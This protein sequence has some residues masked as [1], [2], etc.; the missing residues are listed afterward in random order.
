MDLDQPILA[1]ATAKHAGPLGKSF[2]LVR[3]SSPNVRVMALKKA[4]ES[5]DLVVRVVEIAGKPAAG[6]RLAFVSAVV[7]VREI[8]AQERK[9]A[10]MQIDEGGIAI[11]LSP[12]QLR[13]FAL[14]LSPPDFHVPRVRSQAVPLKTAE[15]LRTLATEML[16]SSLSYGA[17]TFQTNGKA[18]VPRGETIELPTGFT[19]AYILAAAISGDQKARFNDR[20][21]TIEDW[22]G[23]I[24]QWDTR[25]WQTRT[26]DLPPR[27]D[28]PPNAPPRTRTSTEFAG[29][30]P[31]FIKPAS[32]AWYAS[33]SHAAD[34]SNL[35]YQYSYLFAYTLPLAGTTLTLPDNDKIRIVAITVS[36]EGAP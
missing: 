1:F 19:R 25:L 2:S 35:P 13:T 23:K 33:H 14:K 9:I 5:D 16:P 12:Y 3:V 6:V 36:N 26:V 20:E 15:P 32:L 29:L 27:P 21:L 11:S 22:G 31:A 28:A 8:D 7:S 34:G 18:M 17:I 4:E 24:G 10:N 30:T